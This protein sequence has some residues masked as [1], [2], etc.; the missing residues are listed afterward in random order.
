MKFKVKI[1][2][3]LLFM[4]LSV[5]IFAADNADFI[6]IVDQSR[7]IKKSLPNIKDF[8]SK[9]I[10]N[11]IARPED[12]VHILSFDGQ[13]YSR[14]VLKGDAGIIEIGYTLDSI[15]PVGG[16]TDLTN[17][18]L[19]MNKYI[20]ANTEEKS[21]KIIFFLTDGLN[22][23]PQYSRY[24]GGLHHSFFTTANE[25]RQEGG[26]TIFVTGIGEKTDAPAL[27]EI[28]DAE[29]VAMSEQP[30]LEEFDRNV[31][32]KLEE[33]RKE[34][35]TM[36]FIIIGSSTIVAGSASFFVLRKVISA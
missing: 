3:L 28:L 18:V 16:Y 33:A 20:L 35:N 19:E 30:E 12:N 6:V 29:Y 36:L 14:D 22:E 15:K 1:S 13:F 26:W 4:S 32:V 25:Q 5:Q 34:D 11:N 2:V 17:A 9:R 24:Q 7:S 23:P 10:F 31:A 27:A 21:R 8:I